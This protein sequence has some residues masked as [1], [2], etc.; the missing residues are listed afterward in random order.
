MA[1]NSVKPGDMAE[2]SVWLTGE[3]T[4]SQ[5]RHWKS[6][7]CNE[8]A[9][10]TEAQDSVTLGP[11]KFTEKKP[12]EDRVPPAPPHISGINVRLLVGEAKVGFRRPAIVAESGFVE[13]L[14][15]K[16]RERL[17]QITRDA[18]AKKVPGDRLSDR[19]CDQIIE[20]LGPDVAVMTL[21]NGLDGRTTH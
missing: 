10:E 7:I 6:V 2:V 13:D 21:E 20:A 3:E 1:D 16:D 17:R 11:W 12:G 14:T 15:P 9:K 18:H 19:H 8:V 5:L 4:E